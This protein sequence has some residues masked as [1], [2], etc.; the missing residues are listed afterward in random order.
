MSPTELEV[1]FHEYIKRTSSDEK[2]VLKYTN[3]WSSCCLAYY[4]YRDKKV[5]YRFCEPISNSDAIAASKKFNIPI[6]IGN[7]ELEDDNDLRLKLQAFQ[8]TLNSDEVLVLE[9]CQDGGFNIKVLSDVVIGDGYGVIANVSD[10]IAESLIVGDIKNNRQNPEIKKDSYWKNNSGR[11][12]IV[13]YV[14]TE[15]VMCRWVD[16]KKEFAAQLNQFKTIYKETTL[17]MLKYV[18]I[19][20]NDSIELFDTLEECIR[21]TDVKWRQV[22]EIDKSLAI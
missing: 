15:N 5:S 17:P 9:R 2:L 6:I 10:D 11:T 13:E 7:L 18:V 1:K 14:G 20:G 19:R 16:T 3:V 12:F 22:I 21:Q 8:N 4:Y